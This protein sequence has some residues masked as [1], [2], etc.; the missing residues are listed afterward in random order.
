MGYIIL[1]LLTNEQT[2][3]SNMN[4]SIRIP[5]LVLLLS[6]MLTAGAPSVAQSQV[7]LSAGVAVSRHTS[8][9]FNGYR[10]GAGLDL[11]FRYLFGQHVALGINTG[12]FA[13]GHE[14][15]RNERYYR[16]SYIPF[17]LA[18]DVVL[19]VTDGLRL[20]V[21][22]EIGA[23]VFNSSY[24]DRDWDNGNIYRSTSTQLGVGLEAGLQVDLTETLYL[25]GNLGFRAAFYNDYWDRNRGSL[26][27]GTVAIGLGLNL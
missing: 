25:Y 26:G 16:Y 19:P 11:R 23:L 13:H 24:Y 21:G 3:L 17:M 12:Y 10:P 9:Y 18:L 6:V 27:L 20:Y 8:S 2:A 4:S 22:A 7:Q 1:T 5:L 14:D 15:N